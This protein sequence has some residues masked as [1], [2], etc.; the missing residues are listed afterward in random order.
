VSAA[1]DRVVR[2]GEIVGVY[3]VKGWVKVVSYTEPRANILDYSTWLLRQSGRHRPVTV[4]AVRA[5]GRNLIAKLD[6]I[7]DRD[8]ALPLI[9]AGIDVPRS[10]LPDCAP[11]EYYWTD[12]EGLSV[13]S[14]RGEELGTVERLL[15]TG[16]NDVL[17]LAGGRDRLIPF[18]TGTVVREVD[19]EAG[20]IVVDWDPSYWE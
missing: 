9:G 15:A 4:E 1:S 20:R 11:G 16:A 18:V 12:L 5:T 3:G 10:A 6:G 13:V 19:I 8:A 2:L 14:L 7:D 17:V